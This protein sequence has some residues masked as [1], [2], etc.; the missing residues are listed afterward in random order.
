MAAAVVKRD[1]RLQ[2]I[3]S[4][5]SDLSIRILPNIQA[6]HFSLIF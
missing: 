3:G 2:N 5:R 6:K 1:I 4:K